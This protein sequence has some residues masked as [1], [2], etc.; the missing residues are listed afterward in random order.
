METR[1]C[2]FGCGYKLPS[3]YGENETTCGACLDI[4]EWCEEEM[5]ETNDNKGDK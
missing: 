3:E 5:K 1:Y 4:I 2:D